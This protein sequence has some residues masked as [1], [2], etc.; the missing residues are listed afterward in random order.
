MESVEEMATVMVTG[1]YPRLIGWISEMERYCSG[2][3]AMRDL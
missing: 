3:D 1:K 2:I